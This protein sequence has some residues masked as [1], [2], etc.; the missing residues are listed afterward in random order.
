[1]GVAS[2]ERAILL[3]NV[4]ARMFSRAFARNSRTASWAVV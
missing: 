3:K 4:S 2:L 1:M